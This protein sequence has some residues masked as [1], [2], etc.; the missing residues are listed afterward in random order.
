M[1][2]RY[3]AL[4]IGNGALVL[5]AQEPVFRLF[6][7]AKLPLFLNAVM[8]GPSLNEAGV[9]TRRALAEAW[10]RAGGTA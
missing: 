2:R 3:Q 4:M 9:L 6:W 8:F 7:R 10:Q 5:F 1:T